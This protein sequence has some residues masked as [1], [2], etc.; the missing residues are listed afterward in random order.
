[1]FLHYSG[2]GTKLS[3]IFGLATRAIANRQSKSS[4]YK[5]NFKVIRKPQFFQIAVELTPYG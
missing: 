2:F 5:T 3:S 1:M 4:K